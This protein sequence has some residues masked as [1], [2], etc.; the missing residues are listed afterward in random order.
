MREENE[1][2]QNNILNVFLAK[3]GYFNKNRFF[4]KTN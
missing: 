4:N 3:T 1:S 2:K